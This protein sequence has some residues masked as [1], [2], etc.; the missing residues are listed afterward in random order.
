MTILL[1]LGSVVLYVLLRRTQYQVLGGGVAV[2]LVS[3]LVFPFLQSP[4]SSS[5]ES[6]QIAVISTELRRTAWQS[7]DLWSLRRQTLLEAYEAAR[8]TESQY[9]LFPED[10]RLASG[11]AG[12]TDSELLITERDFT[13]QPVIVDSGKHAL[14]DDTAVLRATVSDLE[15]GIVAQADKRYLVPQG[16]FA[17]AL[18]RR[19]LSVLGPEV[20]AYMDSMLVFE[21]GMLRS[22]ADFP[23][24]FPSVLFC[25]ESVDPMGVRSLMRERQQNVPFVAHVVSHGWFQHSSL[26]QSQLDSMLRVQAVWNQVPIVVAGNHARS[27]LYIPNGDILMPTESASGINWSVGTFNLPVTVAET[28]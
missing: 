18:H 28:R 24:R 8:A 23:A 21:K 7:A 9:I 16:E 3:H 19:V 14:T 27:A 4:A 6:V 25:F 22:Q 20:S 10:S 11:D 1:E 26:I 12:V 5:V 17:P 15:T 2:L 13:T